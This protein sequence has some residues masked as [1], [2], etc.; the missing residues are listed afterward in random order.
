MQS[1]KRRSRINSTLRRAARVAMF[2]LSVGAALSSAGATQQSSH[3]PYI[4]GPRVATGAR[5][6]PT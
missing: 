1:T 5:I 2:V 4:V 6:T 3:H